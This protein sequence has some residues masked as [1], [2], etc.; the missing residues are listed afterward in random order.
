[1]AG[2]DTDGASGASAAPLVRLTLFVAGLAVLAG[3]AALAGRASGIDVDDATAPDHGT[4]S[5]TSSGVGN[6]LSD[7]SAGFRLA[8]SPTTLSARTPARLKLQITDQSGSAVSDLDE[9]HDDRRR[10]G[11]ARA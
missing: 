1:M 2:G 4:M 7:S 3:L 6:G 5:E 11:R 10:E 8:L 9:A